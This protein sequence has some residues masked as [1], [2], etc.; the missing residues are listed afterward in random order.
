VRPTS[1]AR[2]NLNLLIC[3]RAIED[4]VRIT[5]A[6]MIGDCVVV[7]YGR[8]SPVLVVEAPV[9]A[10][11]EALKMK[12]IAA[13]RPFNS[14]RYEHERI[15]SEKM[16]LVV[17]PKTLPRT[18]AKDNIRRKAVEEAYKRQLDEIYSLP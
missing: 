9:D 12:I 15:S 7:G 10:D 16:I 13:T 5:C 3:L 11:Q 6:D 2:G 18:S 14:R 17:A 8:P 4:N 1:F